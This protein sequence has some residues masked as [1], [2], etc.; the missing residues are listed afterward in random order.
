MVEFHLQFLPAA[1]EDLDKIADYYLQLNGADSAERITDQILETV[2]HLERYPHLGSLHPDP[3][4]ASMEYRR[5]VSGN[6][7][8]VYRVI[9]DT[10][11]I[12]RIVN[13]RTDYPRL[14]YPS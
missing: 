4:L 11:V 2:E 3:V 5:I 12:Y 6:Y 8:C 7:V 13:G 14:F 9:G 1:V 10:V